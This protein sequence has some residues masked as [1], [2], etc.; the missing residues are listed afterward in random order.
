[1]S[2]IAFNILWVLC[3]LLLLLALFLAVRRRRMAAR[4]AA[5]ANE[6]Y[7]ARQ[8]QGIGPGVRIYMPSYY[9]YQAAQAQ[10]GQGASSSTNPESGLNP[11]PPVYKPEE[12]P[13]SYQDY[14][15]DPRIQGLAS[16]AQPPP[17]SESS[18]PPFPSMSEQ[19][20]QQP[21]ST[22]TETSPSSPPPTATTTTT[23]SHHQQQP[24][25]ASS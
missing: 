8:Q 12:A 7:A 3:V 14:R 24:P 25:A 9:E 19:Q 23:S 18:P 4:N 22:A 5:R 1:M 17:A 10:Y 20:Q 6:A 2:V 21:S 13:P 16:P 15:K 11:P